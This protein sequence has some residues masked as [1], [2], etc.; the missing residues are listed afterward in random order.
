MS[1]SE[2]HLSPAISKMNN[3]FSLFAHVVEGN[4]VLD[5]LRAGDVLVSATVKDEESAGTFR[6][7]RPSS[8]EEDEVIPFEEED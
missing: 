2:R 6:L 3:R 1:V 7:T 5:L 4:D 8:V